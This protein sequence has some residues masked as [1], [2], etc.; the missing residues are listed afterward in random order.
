[1]ATI[2]MTPVG[3]G[4]TLTKTST[5]DK[6]TFNDVP[7][8]TYNVKVTESGYTDFNQQMVVDDDIENFTVTLSNN[9]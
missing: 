9:T 8:G 3:G 2:T 4:S 1:M 6:V 5:S 7:K